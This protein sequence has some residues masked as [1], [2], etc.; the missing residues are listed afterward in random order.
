MVEGDVE[1]A[2]QENQADVVLD[3]RKEGGLNSK[4]NYN[5]RE[6]GENQK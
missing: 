2:R 1:K 6:G 4:V 3:W 5:S